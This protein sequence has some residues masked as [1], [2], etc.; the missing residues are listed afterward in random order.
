[1]RLKSERVK[2]LRSQLLNLWW[3]Q[4]GVQVP[5][6]PHQ[7]LAN[8]TS[9]RH[10]ALSPTTRRE[11]PAR[12]MYGLIDQ[13]GPVVK[14]LVDAE[15][16][17][18][19]NLEWHGV[20]AVDYPPTGVTIAE[21]G[22]LLSR[23]GLLLTREGNELVHLSGGSLATIFGKWGARTYLPKPRQ[24]DGDVLVMTRGLAQ[25]NYYHWTIQMLALIRL[26]NQA[27]LRFDYVA[28]PVRY[29]FTIETLQLLG[30]RH[31]QMIPMHHYTHVQAKRLIIP[32]V[33]S[34]F[35][36]PEAIHYLRNIMSEHDW[37]LYESDNRLR[38]YVARRLRTSRHIVNETELIARLRPLGFQKV[39]LENMPLRR[40]IQMFQRAEVVVGPHGAGFTNA[41][42][43]RPGTGVF[44]ITPTCRPPLFFHYLAEINQL[45]YAVYFAQPVRQK[46]I[47]ADMRVDVDDVV[48]SIRDFIDRPPQTHCATV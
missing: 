1:M 18:P 30:V 40:Q 20:S 36:E 35:P 34:Q 38:I 24:I 44:E 17:E 48:N 4:F 21:Q 15:L 16:L 6:G 22:S 2:R 33:A 27:E 47:D 28:A 37:S 39:Y 23:Q 11:Y 42:Y 8:L 3:R 13:V 14:T 45:P 41:V 9:L 25:R 29:P 7:D 19:F 5:S 10:I 32:S 31:E 12:R 46:G 43:S 26:A